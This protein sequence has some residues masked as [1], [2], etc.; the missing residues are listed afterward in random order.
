[1]S[2]KIHASPY[3]MSFKMHTKPQHMKKELGDE[4]NPYLMSFNAHTTPPHMI[5][6]HTIPHHMIVQG[7]GL[8][9][10]RAV[11]RSAGRVLGVPCGIFEAPQKSNGGEVEGS[12]QSR[13]EG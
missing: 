13:E 9:R 7:G 4:A 3:L 1:M 6:V 8:E 5:N 12:V 10:Q 2:F 11:Q